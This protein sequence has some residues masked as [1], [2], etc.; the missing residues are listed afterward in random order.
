MM[1]LEWISGTPAT[2]IS[3]IFGPWNYPAKSAI[4]ALSL[5]V[6]SFS[7]EWRKNVL[8]HFS[9][10]SRVRTMSPFTDTIYDSIISSSAAIQLFLKYSSD[11]L[12]CLVRTRMYI[13]ETCAKSTH[14]HFQEKKNNRLSL[15]RSCMK[16]Q[17]SRMQMHVE[18][19]SGMT[20]VIKGFWSKSFSVATSMQRC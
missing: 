5:W 12:F 16:H 15:S 20:H 17:R 1:V 13:A 4:F 2:C 11:F 6:L 14:A 7:S 18:T 8:V 19:E 10:M 9:G 3:N